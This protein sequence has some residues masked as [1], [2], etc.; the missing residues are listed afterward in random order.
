[1]DEI[2]NYYYNQKQFMG[3]V[4]VARGDQVVFSKSYGYAN[5]EWQNAFTADTKFRLGS[6]TKQFTAACIML[7]QEDGKLKTSDRVSKYVLNAPAAWQK[8]TMRNLLTHTSG[9]PNFTSLADYAKTQALPTTPE[10]TMAR[11]LDLPLDFQPGEKFE[12]SNSNYIVLGYI[13]EKASGQSYIQFLT[14]RILKPLGLSDTGYDTPRILP[15]RAAGY[16]LHDKTIENTGLIDMTVPFAA[17]SLYSTT[18]DLMRWNLGIY[19][20]RLLRPASLTE[21][22]TPYKDDYAYGIGVTVKNGRKKLSHGGGIDGFNTSLIYFPEDRVS[23]VALSNL[24]GPGVGEIADKAADI[25][26]GKPVVLPSERKEVQVPQATLQDYVGEYE[27]GE[28]P[29]VMSVSLKDGA[30]V[31]MA[32][33]QGQPAFQLHPE[34]A[35]KF[36]VREVDAEVEFVRDASGKT[37]ELVLYQGGE[38]IHW[39]RK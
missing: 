14:E 19:G 28:P 18:T 10:K 22:T 5:L 3:S 27:T 29:H 20:G 4:L 8:I 36:F 17:G 16:T 31:L 37:K 35:A 30:G 26:Y 21:M 12:Y 6:L 39:L 23:V 24:N 15:H 33:I 25:L 38:T 7:L 1:M 2:A 13:I 11:F 34:S 9:I 32:Q